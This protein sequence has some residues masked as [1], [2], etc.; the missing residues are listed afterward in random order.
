MSKEIIIYGA[1]GAGRELAFSLSLEKDEERKLLV[2]AFVDDDC[3]LWGK[4][5][6]KIYLPG[7][8]EWLAHQEA[9]VALTIVGHP[10]VRRNLVT[11]LKLLKGIFFPLIVGPNN[12][13]SEFAELGEG[14]IISLS[15]NWID[16]NVKL[17]NFVFVCCSTRIGHDVSIG[18]YTS[19]FSDVDISGGAQISADCIIGSGATINPKVGIGRGAVIG[20]GSVVTRDIPPGVV[21]AGVPARIIKEIK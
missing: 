19:I 7:G 21:A 13:V 12:V 8:F 11:R 15:F 9:A 10:L 18:D 6:N 20:A 2:K 5:V 1:G 17:G 14:C 3:S 16:P 4:T